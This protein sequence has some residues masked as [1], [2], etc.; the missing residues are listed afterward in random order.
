MSV[1]AVTLAV[2][3]FFAPIVQARV[4][5]ERGVNSWAASQPMRSWEADRGAGDQEV[6]LTIITGVESALHWV[7]TPK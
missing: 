4:S 1:I 6:H 3:F 5:R 2:Y 7:R